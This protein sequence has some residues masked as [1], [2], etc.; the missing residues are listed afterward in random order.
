MSEVKF[1]GVIPAVITVFNEDGTFDWEGNKR[2]LDHLIKAGVH[3]LFILGSSGEFMHMSTTER[4][5]FA[6]FVVEY[7]N[8]RVPVTVGTG[9][10]STAE[11]IELTMHAQEIGAD[12][13]GIITP[14]YWILS[15]EA[16]Y[17]HYASVAQA[18]DIPII[19]Y[20]YPSLTG[21]NL[22]ASLV[23]RLAL[24]FPNIL[25]IKD[26]I[27]NVAHLRELV[28]TVK[29]VKPEFAVLAGY[30]DHILNT[31]ALGGDG[32]ITAITNFAPELT[33]GLYNSF[34]A[35]DLDKSIS[36]YQKIRVLNRIYDVDKPSIAAI[37]EA[38]RLTGLDIQTYVR[39]PAVN[40]S[41]EVQRVVLQ[42]LQEAGLECNLTNCSVAKDDIRVVSR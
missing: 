27:D 24:D 17:N 40:A 33:V 31:L 39:K 30:E 12:A 26:T 10:S 9:S 18:V 13:V 20:H 22:S 16:L 23:A 25:G 36:L 8:K 21:Q 34:V 42:L 5:K 19:I 4:K 6:E 38:C 3:G 15:E 7:V 37:K 32:I 14:Y 35:G 1:R 11:V 41:R 29:S 2:L 28:L